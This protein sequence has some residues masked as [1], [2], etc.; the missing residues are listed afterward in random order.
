[1]PAATIAHTS[2]RIG[3]V[4]D[5]L[6]RGIVSH[7]NDAARALGV[8]PGMTCEAAWRAMQAA[9]IHDLPVAPVVEHRHEFELD[10]GH[11]AVCIDSASLIRA[12]DAG[13]IVITGSHGGLIGGDAARAINVQAAFAAFNDAGVGI[14]DAGIGRLVPLG[15][16]GIAAVTVAHDSARIGDGVSTLRDGVISHVNAVAQRHGARPGLRLADVLPAIAA[17][18]GAI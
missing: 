15:R 2:A 11:T 7:A 16:S 12:Q 3:D 1:M 18:V 9:A 8:A 14:D 6:R 17:A 10:G 13:R 4:A 5:L